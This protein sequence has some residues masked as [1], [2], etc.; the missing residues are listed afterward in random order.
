MY[1]KSLIIAHSGL[2]YKK[3]FVISEFR[4][5]AFSYDKRQVCLIIKMDD[6]TISCTNQNLLFYF[7]IPYYH[8]LIFSFKYH[9]RGDRAVEEGEGESKKSFFFGFEHSFMSFG[10]DR[11]FSGSCDISETSRDV[12]IPRTVLESSMEA[13]SN[14]MLDLAVSLQ[15]TDLRA[16][17]IEPKRELKK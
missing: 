7:K 4:D 10:H 5:L 8:S 15:F 1:L 3:H 6:I 13:V 17:K 2:V 14:G 9:F 11:V 12:A 16:L